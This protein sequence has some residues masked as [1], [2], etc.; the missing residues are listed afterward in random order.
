[1]D[2]CLKF[3]AFGRVNIAT[4]MDESYRL[5]VGR[6]NDEVSK[7]WHIL[8]CLIDCVKFC[9]VFWV[10]FVWQ[11]WKW[12]QQ[13]IQGYPQH[14]PG[15][16]QKKAT[17]LWVP[18]CDRQKCLSRL[19]SECHCEGTSHAEQGKAQDWTVSHLWESRIQGLLWCSGSV[20]GS[21]EIQPPGDIF[22]GCGSVE[23]SHYHSHDNGCGWVVFLNAEESQDVPAQCSGPGMS[24]CTGHALHGE[25]ASQEHAWFQWEGYWSLCCFWKR[26][27]QNFN[28]SN[29]V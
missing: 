5:A 22:W 27:K 4:Q 8:A 1:M 17:T 16:R 9:G 25:G 3:S 7:N 6:R 2:S 15:S 23:H 28:T 18:H 24:E 14:N 13:P 12:G 26:D 19:C 10:S 21:A 20:P 11:R 29:G